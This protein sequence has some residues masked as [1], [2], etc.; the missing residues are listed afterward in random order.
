VARKFSGE[1]VVSGG[2]APEI[3]EPAEAALDD[4]APFV[5]AFAEAVE[6]FLLDLLGITGSRHAG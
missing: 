5:G 1:F 6:N 4:V 2:D 3:V